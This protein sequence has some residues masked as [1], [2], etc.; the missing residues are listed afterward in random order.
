MIATGK[1]EGRMG[2]GFVKLVNLHGSTLKVFLSD[3]FYFL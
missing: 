3:F 2:K 1:M